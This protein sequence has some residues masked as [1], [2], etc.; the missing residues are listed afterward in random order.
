MIYQ[1]SRLHCHVKEK[2][3]FLELFSI[4]VIENYFVPHRVEQSPHGQQGKIYQILTFKN[5]LEIKAKTIEA[6]KK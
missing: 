3:D 6:M 2:L 1:L 5:G 4:P